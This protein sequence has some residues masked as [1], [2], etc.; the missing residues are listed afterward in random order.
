MNSATVKNCWEWFEQP[1]YHPFYG[2]FWEWLYGQVYRKAMSER[3]LEK[4]RNRAAWAQRLMTR[5]LEYR[6]RPAE[7]ETDNE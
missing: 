5:N 6:S 3:K 7:S 1:Q 2:C 4:L